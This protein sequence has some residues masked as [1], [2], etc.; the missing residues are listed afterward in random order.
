MFSADHAAQAAHGPPLC[1]A[2]VVIAADKYKGS[3]SSGEVAEAL[4][5]G[6]A[7]E[8]PGAHVDAVPVA[9]GGDGSL[10]VALACGASPIA[11]TVANVDGVT[12]QTHIGVEGSRAI[13]EAALVC[14]LGAGTPDGAAALRATS[15]GVGEAILAALDAGATQIVLATGGTATS[16]GGAGMLSALGLRLLDEAGRPVTPGGAGLDQLATIDARGLDDRLR[17]IDL[18]LASDVDNPLLGPLGAASVYGPQKGAGPA[19]VAALERGIARW[20][21]LATNSGLSPAGPASAPGAGAGGGLGF[22]ALLLGAQWVSGADYFLDLA[23]FDK[24]LRGADLVITGEGR[25]D[26]QS[27]RGKAP[28]IVARRAQSARVPV[29]AVA[30]SCL[31]TPAQWRAAG[32]VAVDTLTSLDPRCEHDAELSRKLLRE[33]GRRIGLELAAGEAVGALNGNNPSTLASN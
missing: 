7:A 27:L 8:L 31:L 26:E 5:E 24:K 25:L 3:L 30:G 15:R 18:I 2:R 22:A 10:A 28:S 9:D 12:R 13:I 29:R 1:R 32:L 11:V 4:T 21:A 33:V 16:D 17:G 23:G 20:V 6:L 14:G 19:E